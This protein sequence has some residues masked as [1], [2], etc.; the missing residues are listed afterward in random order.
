MHPDHPEDVCY[1]VNMFISGS[2][3]KDL[4]DEY[5][6]TAIKKGVPPLFTNLQSIYGDKS[7]V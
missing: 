6:R 5:L 7:K 2:V 1:L 3:F 4:V